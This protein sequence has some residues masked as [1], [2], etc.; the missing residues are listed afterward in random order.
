MK[1]KSLSFCQGKGSLSHNNRDF[2]PKNVDESRIKDN[3]TFIKEPIAEAYEKIFCAAVERYNAKQ[4]RDDR[5]IKNGYYE[6]V[7]NSK[8]RNTVVT[9]PDK[10]NSFYE[11]LVQIGDKDDSGCGT[12]DGELVAECLI[13]YFHGFTE[14]NPN[15]YVFQATLH[16]NEATPHL[17]I[18]YIPVGHYKRGV[19]TQNG[20]SQALKEMGFTGINAINDWRIRERKVLEEICNARGFHIKEPQKARGSFA[21]EEYK[22]YKDNIN[23]LQQQQAKETAQ[24]DNLNEQVEF[25]QGHYDYLEKEIDEKSVVVE[26]LEG[27]QSAL[28][29][30]INQQTQQ[31]QSNKAELDK[32][33]KKKADVKA[34]EN[35]E[36]KHTI[37][38]DKVTVSADDF[39]NLQT[40]GKKQIVSSKST[41]KL[42]SQVTELIQEN[43]ALI[44]E[45]KDLKAKSS[46]SIQ[47]RLE[48]DRLNKQVNSLQEKLS[49]ILDFIE[50]LNLKA[51]LEVF[52]S[53]LLECERK[54]T[55]KYEQEL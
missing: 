52:L 24:L 45:N 48:N 39:E 7:F 14:R 35:I 40:M 31:I 28:E 1:I 23:E 19:D 22:A 51:R 44:V 55:K 54:Q 17:H 5:K 11:D 37:F 42:K 13:E 36:V 21:V 26:Q 2:L 33:S 29:S 16:N 30:E 41:K 9:S 53:Q 47:L 10:R 15:F 46:N 43:Q 25:S 20:L 32:I 34:V 49:R 27:K 50:K 18:D 8:P 3:I 6:H 38:G 12:P 4:T